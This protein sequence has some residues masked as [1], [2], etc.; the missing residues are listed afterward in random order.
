MMLL[1]GAK[2]GNPRAD[3]E[4]EAGMNAPKCLLNTKKWG[5]QNWGNSDELQKP[6][7]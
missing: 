4:E 2:V 1:R 6:E 5:V 3:S 7:V